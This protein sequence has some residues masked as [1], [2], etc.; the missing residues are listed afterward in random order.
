MHLVERLDRIQR[1][2]ESHL[3]FT[4]GHANDRLAQEHIA[5]VIVALPVVL[6]SR[7]VPL[8]I[9][10][11]KANCSRLVQQGFFEQLRSESHI[12]RR[13][14]LTA[15]AHRVD[16]TS[17]RRQKEF[18]GKRAA[19]TFVKTTHRAGERTENRIAALIVDFRKIARL[20]KTFA[21]PVRLGTMSKINREQ[22]TLIQEIQQG[23]SRVLLLA[24]SIFHIVQQVH[25]S[26]I[27]TVA[28]IHRKAINHTCHCF[29]I[30][31]MRF[32][33]RVPA[34]YSIICRKQQRG[35][36]V[37]I[38]HDTDGI[39]IL[40]LLDILRKLCHRIHRKASHGKVQVILTIL[41]DFTRIKDSEKV[42][43]NRIFLFER[44]K[45]RCSQSA[46]NSPIIVMAAARQE[47][48]LQVRA[49]GIHIRN[50]IADCNR[51]NTARCIGAIDV[52]RRNHRSRKGLHRRPARTEGCQSNRWF[53]EFIGSDNQVLQLGIRTTQILKHTIITERKGLDLQARTVGA[54]AH[55]KVTHVLVRRDTILG[56][57]ARYR[58]LTDRAQVHKLHN[59]RSRGGRH[60]DNA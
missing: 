5:F 10:E 8:G 11:S 3:Q 16:G 39:I 9:Q 13:K 17:T 42:L 40:R 50:V 57:S 37:R 31:R 35:S 43:D 4:L 23:F 7:R 47:H 28:P 34:I 55:G 21:R 48:V 54:F 36:P 38:V 18:L 44:R 59:P 46:S 56:H 41:A 58:K 2:I 51:R 52:L 15:R 33:V 20:Q 32:T 29:L 30:T 14:S 19:D 53:Q 24:G 12:I 45:V 25:L 60:I 6:K 27:P 26:H 1:S 22:C 49:N